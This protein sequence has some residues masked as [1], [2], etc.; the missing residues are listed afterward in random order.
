MRGWAKGPRFSPMTQKITLPLQRSMRIRRPG[1]WVSL[2]AGA[3]ALGVVGV[4]GPARLIAQIEGDRGI[5]PVL[6]TGDIEVSGVAVNTTGKSAAEARAA[7]WKEAYRLAWAKV[8]GPALDDG[9]LSAMVTRVSVQNEQVG[10]HRYI[11]TLGISFDRAKA[12]QF[13]AGGGGG[14]RSAPMLVIPVLYA[15]GTAQV[16]EIKGVWQRAW[17]E[18]RTG[19]SAV[20]YVRP[21]GAGGDSLLITA[22]QPGRRSRLWWRGLLDQYGASDVLI[23]EARLE[24][25]W[26]GGPIMGTFNARYGPDNRHLASFTLTAA[27]EGEVPTMMTQ[28]VQQMDRLYAD[29]LQ[30]GGLRSDGV[31]IDHPAVDPGL[32]SVIAAGERAA[33]VQAAAARGP[34]ADGVGDGVSATATPVAGPVTPEATSLSVQFSSPDARSVD[35]ALSALRGTSGVAS[36]STSSI[37]IGGTSVMRVS[38]A[39]SI[40]QLAAAL[41]EHG[42]QVTVG[43][44]ALRIRRAEP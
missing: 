37:A 16:Y 33:A 14:Q 30:H 18:F 44:G 10:P 41:R 26:P 36:A 12:A 23:P 8:N 40:V 5:A 28:A 24:R 3:L 7:G 11:A 22:G 20:D 19:A 9:S 13:V 35:A 25:Q 29:A 42:W 6:N 17:A 32:A 38:Y 15:G 4:I 21:S 34:V 43:S 2:G 1:L 27:D 31:S 39:G